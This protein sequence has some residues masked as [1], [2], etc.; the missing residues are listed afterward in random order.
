MDKQIQI[1]EAEIKRLTTLGE[2]HLRRF[3]REY[4]KEPIGLNTEFDR[5]YFSGW[6]HCIETIYNARTTELILDV[7]QTN[8]G[9]SIPHC[10]TLDK[11]GVPTGFDP[12]A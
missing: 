12:H 5:G 2:S 11:D 7:I 3:H 8:T 10:G 1:P 6:R 4:E 9:L